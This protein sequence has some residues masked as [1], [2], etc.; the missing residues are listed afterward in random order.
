MWQKIGLLAT[1]TVFYLMDKISYFTLSHYEN[2]FQLRTKQFSHFPNRMRKFQM[3]NVSF[4]HAILSWNIHAPIRIKNVIIN[5]RQM[6]EVGWIFEEFNKRSFQERIARL[7]YTN[8][9]VYLFMCVFVC[10][11]KNAKMQ[12]HLWNLK[13]CVFWLFWLCFVSRALL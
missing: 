13:L 7:T 1:R 5:I 3:G 12:F 6:A 4:I 11:I 10:F 8:T 2:S 9:Y